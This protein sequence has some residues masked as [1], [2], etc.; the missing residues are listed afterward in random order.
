MSDPLQYKDMLYL[1]EEREEK[2]KICFKD[3]E[4]IRHKK[5]EKEARMA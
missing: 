4:I 2:V 5:R 3:T 1:S